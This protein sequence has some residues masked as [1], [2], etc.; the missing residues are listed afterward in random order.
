M[1]RTHFTLEAD[2]MRDISKLI[3]RYRR[4]EDMTK[5]DLAKQMRMSPATLADRIKRTPG[6]WTVGQLW[7]AAKILHIPKDEIDQAICA[8]TGAR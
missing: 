4:V 1:P 2:R 6:K 3:D 7:S 8:G 5:E